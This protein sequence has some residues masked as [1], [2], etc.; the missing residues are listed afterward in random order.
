MANTKKSVT[1]SVSSKRVTAKRPS[2]SYNGKRKNSSRSGSANA[3][4]VAAKT[5]AAGV[6]AGSLKKTNGKTLI[7]VL[8]AFILSFIIGA[9]V[10]FFV[11]KNDCFDLVGDQHVY[12]TENE[13]YVEEGVKITEFGIDVSGKV[14]IESDLPEGNLPVGDYYVTYTVKTLKFGMIYPVK[15][16]R[17]ITVS[18]ESEGGE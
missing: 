8:T 1:R 18:P 12:L 9:G 2:S 14:L 16:I 6:I 10:C 5:A 7:A 3:L 15:R 11:G 13:T 17:L 4:G